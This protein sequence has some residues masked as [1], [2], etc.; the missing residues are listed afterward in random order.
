MN[1]DA[2]THSAAVGWV[3]IIAVVAFI[4]MWL[5]CYGADSSWTWGYNSLSDFGISYGTDAAAFFNYGLMIS[6]ALL[7]AYGIGRLQY[8]KGKAGYAAGGALLA[9]AGFSMVGIALLTKDVQGA[10]YHNLFAYMAALFISISLIVIAVQEYRDNM[11]FP[12]GVA[13]MLLIAVV[14]FAL[15]FNFAK[16]EVY[17]IIAALIW[18]LMDSAVLIKT[19]IQEGLA[20]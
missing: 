4:V 15:M 13:I 17:A 12:V 3:G 5:A 10:D 14:C 2:K 18:V 6:G 7:G 11:V 8:N 20:Q 9:L 16:F 1:T 19:G